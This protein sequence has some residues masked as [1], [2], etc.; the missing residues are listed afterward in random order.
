MK[1]KLL[2]SALLFPL[3]L[4]AQ[5]WETEYDKALLKAQIENKPIILVF[6]GSD[7]C[8]PCKLLDKQIWQSEVFKNYARDNYILYKADF[9]RKKGNQLTEKTTLRNG[10]LAEKFNKKGYFPL[11]VVL[12]KDESVLGTAGYKRKEPKAYITLF[13]SFLK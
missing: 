11:V 7:W 13:N 5:N 12:D 1:K 10:E 4:L 3:C 2:F 6:A 9:P 8:A